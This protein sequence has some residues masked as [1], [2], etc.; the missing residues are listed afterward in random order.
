MSF[1]M[2]AISGVLTVPTPSTPEPSTLAL[3][4]IGFAALVAFAGRRRIR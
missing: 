2:Y 1:A 4:A 3:A